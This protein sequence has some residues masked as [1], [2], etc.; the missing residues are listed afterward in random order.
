VKNKVIFLAAIAVLSLL[1]LP[2][3]AKETPQGDESIKIDIVLDWT[4]KSTH[5]VLIELCQRD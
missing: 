1:L 3:C 4:P 2:S 5:G